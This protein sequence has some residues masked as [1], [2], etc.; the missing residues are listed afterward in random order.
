MEYTHI[1]GVAPPLPPLRRVVRGDADVTDGG[2][3]PY[4]EHLKE[5]GGDEG[6]SEEGRKE[7]GRREEGL[8]LDLKRSLGTGVP[9]VKS[10]VMQ[11]AVRP[12]F[13]QAS[14]I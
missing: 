10:L 3:K 7:E 13:S 1:L 11:R 5:E 2:I 6:W 9:H 4:V 8:T 12:F 14:V